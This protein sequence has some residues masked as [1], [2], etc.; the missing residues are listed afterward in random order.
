ML[1]AREALTYG[2]Q[3]NWF[4][5]EPQ[6]FYA[7]LQRKCDGVFVVDVNYHYNPKQDWWDM[8]IVIYA[9]EN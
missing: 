4:C 7:F 5:T 1:T 9:P 6:R 3:E 2:Q 8:G